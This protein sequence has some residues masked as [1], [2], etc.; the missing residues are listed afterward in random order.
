MGEKLDMIGTLF[1]REEDGEYKE[2]GEFRRVDLITTA[3]LDDGPG[4]DGW[5]I[6][7]DWKAWGKHNFMFGVKRKGYKKRLNS[8]CKSM[9]GMTK[10]ELIFRKKKKRSRKRIRRHS[11]DLQLL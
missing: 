1:M 11:Q 5:T 8:L 9:F 10:V 4:E 7:N 3:D 2:I 6:D